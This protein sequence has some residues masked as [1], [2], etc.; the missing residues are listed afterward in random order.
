MRPYLTWV[1]LGKVGR[2]LTSH[3]MQQDNYSVNYYPAAAVRATSH[4]DEQLLS[5][6]FSDSDLGRISILAVNIEGQEDQPVPGSEGRVPRIPQVHYLREGSGVCS[7]CFLG[8]NT[9]YLKVI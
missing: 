9:T 7:S 8:V 2:Y 1:T 6:P 3:D 4:S 5:P